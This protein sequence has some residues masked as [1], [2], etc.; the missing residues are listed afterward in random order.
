MSKTLF[1]VLSLILLLLFL[2]CSDS[3]FAIFYFIE[4]ETPQQDL[5]LENNLSISSMARQG[6]AYYIAAGG[7]IWTRNVAED[8]WKR[9]S[10]PSSA[11]VCTALAVYASKLYAGFMLTN[12]SFA[13]YQ[14]PAGLNPSWTEELDA[15]VAGKQIIRLKYLNPPDRLAVFTED[16]GSFELLIYNAGYT[17]SGIPVQTTAISD[18]TY[19]GANYWATLAEKVYTGTP[20]LG[21][22]PAGELPASLSGTY[23]GVHYSSALTRYYLATSEGVIHQSDDGT[24]WSASDVAEVGGENV[25]FS[26]FNEI[27]NNILAGTLGYGFYETPGG[28]ITDPDYPARSEIISAVDLYAGWVTGFFIDAQK[29]FVLTAGSGLWQNSYSAGAWQGDWVH[30]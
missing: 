29:V 14:A 8:I 18:V 7:A 15:A 3:E 2:S 11:Q 28:D 24:N 30:E 5:S 16:A 19:D 17:D 25:P 23:T 9:V 21:E 22:K 10:L 27:G 6:T 26:F 1:G 4:N 12:G 20:P 13:F